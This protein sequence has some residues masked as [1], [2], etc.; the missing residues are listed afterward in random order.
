MNQWQ[1]LMIVTRNTLPLLVG[2]ALNA[3]L[4]LMLPASAWPKEPAGVAPGF[5]YLVGRGMSD[6]T[7]PVTGLQ[8]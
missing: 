6:I 5:N 2:T 7:G 4:C 3:L 8:F 1:A